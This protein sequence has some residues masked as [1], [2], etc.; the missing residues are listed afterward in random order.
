MSEKPKKDVFK[1]RFYQL[2]K[3]SDFE[4]GCLSRA[5]EYLEQES[6][7]YQKNPLS[8]DELDAY[9]KKLGKEIITALK[10]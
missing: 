9:A 8:L 4:S 10:E 5:D 1:D 2:L 7:Q 3:V 6:V